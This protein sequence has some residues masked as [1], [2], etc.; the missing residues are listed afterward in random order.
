[1]YKNATS[2]L[3]DKG[4]SNVMTFKGGIPEWVKAGFNLNQTG[5]LNKDKISTISADAL[6]GSLGN[7]QIV[8]IR[9]SSLYEMGW[10][11]GSI[12]IPLGKLSAEYTT[13]PKGKP[14]VVVDHAGKQVLAASRFLKGNGYADVQRL[15][16][17]LMAWSQKGYALEK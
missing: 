9:S 5:S 8:D 4:Y 17:G 10:I 6:N 12:K 11:H 3:A 13:I 14:I 2:L 7:V 15:Q 16:G 1:M